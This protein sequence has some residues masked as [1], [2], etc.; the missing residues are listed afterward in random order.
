MSED[1][2]DSAV[3][4]SAKAVITRQ[5]DSGWSVVEVSGVRVGLAQR[6]VGALGSGPYWLLRLDEDY[7]P[8]ARQ[9][10]SLQFAT[11]EHV[12]ERAAKAFIARQEQKRARP[13]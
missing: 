11:S 3:E 8:S 10:G 12:R 2:E 5:K 1:I 4:Q 6:F 13:N 7:L 9:V